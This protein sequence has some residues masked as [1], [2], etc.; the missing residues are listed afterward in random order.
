MGEL[1]RILP[2]SQVKG[3][4]CAGVEVDILNLSEFK[5]EIRNLVL[6]LEQE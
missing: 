2:K 4:T 3:V 5:K 1:E 6:V